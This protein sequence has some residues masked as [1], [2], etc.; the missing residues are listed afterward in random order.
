MMMW[1]DR[2]KYTLADVHAEV[3]AEAAKHGFL[4]LDLLPPFAKVPQQEIMLDP[5][6]MHPN[7]RGHGL[8]SEALL[9]FLG[10]HP[11]LL[12]ARQQ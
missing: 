8:A 3:A 7:P 12:R 2:S 9:E 6:D 1:E 10:S 4:V 11:E 5:H